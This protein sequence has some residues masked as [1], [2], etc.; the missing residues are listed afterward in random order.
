LLR[1][2]NYVGIVTGKTRSGK[3]MSAL[4]LCMEIDPNFTIDNVI[5]STREFMELLHSGQLKRGSMILWDEA[6]VG[7]A[8]RDW[9]S[10][11]NKSLNYVLQTWGHQNIG[12]IL[13]VPDFSMIDSQTR[14]L[15]NMHFKTIKLIRSK[16]MARLKPYLLSPMEKA[17]TK[18][19]RPRYDISG[20]KLDI[21]YIEI[22]KPPTKMVNKYLKKKESFTAKLN[23][24]VL[25]DIQQ[26]DRAK[27]QELTKTVTDE[28]L[29]KQAWEELKDDIFIKGGKRR[30]NV[31][32]VKKKL[33]LTM[34]RAFYILEQIMEKAKNENYPSLDS[35]D[36]SKDL[37][38][39]D[40]NDRLEP[41]NLL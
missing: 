17:E 6:G 34:T 19:V 35:E 8:T 39:D 20:K 11:L 25:F 30:L 18:K 36:F 23:A 1:G 24:D 26:M 28:E 31:Y 27:Q 10:T 4:R 32:L 14:R 33:G 38:N 2:E 22:K 3:S 37:E 12:L 13:T 9:Y 21:E 15:V 7:I 41:T 40:I 5:F 16:N 29:I